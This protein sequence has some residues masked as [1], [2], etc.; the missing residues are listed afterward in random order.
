MVKG[1]WN[2][3]NKQT[4]K[5]KNNNP[6]GGKKKKKEKRGT[7]EKGWGRGGAGE[8]VLHLAAWNVE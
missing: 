6:K 2:Q 5:K 4:K 1:C 7:E 3:E 8:E